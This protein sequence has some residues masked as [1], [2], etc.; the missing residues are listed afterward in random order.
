MKSQNKYLRDGRVIKVISELDNNKLLIREVVKGE[1]KVEID[2]GYIE[3]DAYIEGQLLIIDSSDIYDEPPVVFFDRNIEEKKKQLNEWNN[4]IKEKREEL[5]NVCT[6]VETKK[7]DVNKKLEELNKDVEFIEKNTSIKT[8][9]RLLSEPVTHIVIFYYGK[10]AIEKYNNCKIF[11]NISFSNGKITLDSHWGFDCDEDTDL[12]VN[13]HKVPCFSYEE[14][15]SVVVKHRD[16]HIEEYKKT[17]FDSINSGSINLIESLDELNID[18]DPEFRKASI[19][20]IIDNIKT[21]NDKKSEEI[22]ENELKIRK[23]NNEQ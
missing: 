13:F 5:K 21:E 20:R 19:E 3:T 7:Q 15:V 17:R 8:L 18:I 10:I 16:R 23:Y 12:N 22:R 4:K 1:I 14:A 11:S 2:Y 6:E 9:K